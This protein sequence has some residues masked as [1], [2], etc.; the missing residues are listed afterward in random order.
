MWGKNAAALNSSKKKIA[1]LK[2]IIAVLEKDR[3]E[4]EE[5]KKKRQEQKEINK[6][7]KQLYEE[8]TKQERLEKELRNLRKYNDDGTLRTR[9]DELELQKKERALK[10]EKADLEKKI[11]LRRE[12]QDLVTREDNLKKQSLALGGTIRRNKT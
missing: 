2:E 8:K 10:Q 6:Q 12:N 5:L 11:K 4:K 3:D 1:R 7:L 9:S